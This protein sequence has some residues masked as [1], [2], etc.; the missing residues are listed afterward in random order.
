MAAS[1][2][3][4]TSLGVAGAPRKSLS[5]ERLSKANSP[6]QSASRKSQVERAKELPSNLRS[7]RTCSVPLRL[8]SSAI[9]TKVVTREGSLT[10][11]AS[12]A[13]KRMRS[14]LDL[15]V[16][17]LIQHTQPSACSSSR[18]HTASTPSG[19]AAQLPKVSLATENGR[20][21]CSISASTPVPAGPT[22]R[23]S[24]EL[25]YV[26]RGLLIGGRQSVRDTC[27]GS[28]LDGPQPRSSRSST[29]MKST[30]LPP[31]W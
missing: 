2:A 11:A 23:I 19:T 15:N 26:A 7:G 5:L 12:A 6:R 13:M 18:P 14:E 22:G 30:V 24:R 16:G 28:L 25:R 29:S 31:S 20:Y 27:T 3:A 21:S 4:V 10:S 8:P 17:M 1:S 9:S